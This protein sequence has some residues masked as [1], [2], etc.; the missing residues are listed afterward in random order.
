MCGL[1]LPPVRRDPLRGID[2][3][4]REQLLRIAT[5]DNPSCRNIANK[6]RGFELRD[7]VVAIAR[8]LINARGHQHTELVIETECL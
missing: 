8:H 2:R 6:A 7:V 1:D 3:I 4:A 5:S